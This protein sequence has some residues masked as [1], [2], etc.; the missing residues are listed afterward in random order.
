MGS[1]QQEELTILNIYGPNTGAPR[2]IRQV[3]NDLQKDLDSHTIIVG[4]FNTPLSILDRSTRQKINKDTQGLNSDLE[5]ANLVDIYRTL[6]PKST[7]YT[8]FSAPHHTYSKIDHI[9]GSKALLNKCKTTEIITNSLSDHSAIKLELRI[10]KP[11]QN[12]TASWKL[13][14]WLLN[15]DWVNNEMK[16]EIKKFFETN[17]NEDTTCQ[18]LWD[19]FKAVS[20]GKYIAI[21][22]H[23]RRM[24]R[25]KIDTLS[26][27]LKELEEQDQKNSK[28]SRRQEI[29]KIRAELKEIETRKTLQKINKSK[30]WFFEKINKID[31]PLAR[32]IKNKR[33]NNQI[34]AIKNDKGEITTDSTEIQTIIREYYKQLYAHKLV[35]LEEMD[36]FL[37]SCV[38]PSLNQEEAETMNR[39]I[40]RSEVEAAIK[41]LPHKKSPGP[42]GF[43]AEFYQT[44]K[45]ELEPFLLKLFQTIQK[46]GILPKSF[47]ETNIILI[48]KPGR[49]PTRKENF[50]PISMMNIDAKIFNKILASR[51]QQQ[52]KKLIHHDQVGFIPGM[53][54]WFNIRKSINVIHHINRTKNKNHMIIS[55]DA[56]KAFDK[57]QQPFMLKTLNKLGIDGTYIKVIKAIYDKPTANIILNGQ[58]LEAF[59]LKSGT[60]QGCPLSPLLFNIVLEVL[61]RAIRQEKEIKGIQIGKVEA[62]LSLFADD[63]IVYLEDPITS[64]QKLLKLINN[65][66][67]V[68]GYKINVQKSQAFVYTNNRL[69]ESQIKSELP[70]AIATK[71]I[72]Y[73]GIQLTRNVRDLFK[74]NYKPLLNEIREDTN[75][76]RNIPCSWLGRINIVKMAILPKVIYRINAIPIKLPL[77][78][79]TELEKTTMNF[80]WNQ[81][82]ARIA[83]SIL[84]KKNTA[85]GITLPDFKLYYKATVI[86]TA[87]YWYQNRD[88]D[89]W[90]KTEAP[91]ATQHT[92][93]YSIFDK[94]DKNKQ[95]GKDSMF[96]K[97]CWEN[98]LAMCRK[99]KLDP[100][101]TP[102]T[103]INSRWIKDLNIRPGT[104]KTL[105]GNLG[106]TIQD[107]GV[108]KDFMNKT[109]RALATKAKIDKWDL[110]KLH[111]FCTAK[112]TV[113]RVDRQPTEWEKIF[114]V[115]P[116]DKGLISRIY[117]QLKQIYRKKTNKPIQK[118]AK[119]M[120]RYF[121]KEDIYEANNHMKKCSS[122]LVI[123]E[124][125]IKT[126]LRYHLTPVRMA[127]IKKSGDNRCWRG[128]GE[129]G[130]LLHCWWE[131]KLVQPLWK[132]V[133]RFLKALEIEIPFDPAIPLLGIYPKDYKS[134]YY[135]DTCTRMFIAAL[136][137]IAKTWNQPKCP[138]IIDWIGKMWHIYT[139]EYYA[140]IRN[141]EFVSFVG[142]WMNL[143]NIILSKLTQEQK[144]KHRIFSLIGG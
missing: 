1:I 129:K 97:W 131:C 36:K 38:L 43:T 70:F 144:M 95:W 120:N 130:T 58:K 127:I 32:L 37:D 5:Q 59:P 140:A 142:T 83:K 54:G 6:H 10:Q 105:E 50:R 81:K 107:I 2:Y 44:H 7:E 112:E 64:A 104:I 17:E 135:K 90:N 73:L 116:S 100:F 118:W 41:S 15:V 26:S 52:I 22:A 8:F 138:L 80:I 51:L 53:Q 82:R 102:Y 86:K 33:E 119:D 92:Y 18:N 12:R 28:P 76:W 93:N 101:L 57:I 34:D 111:S 134:F 84:S 68:S 114:A 74:E 89:Q 113:T 49:D 109:P 42:D 61:A 88:I 79:F 122:S 110:M 126:T 143:E 35:N 124:M 121:T 4:D 30:S 87:W 62:K 31:R 25:S 125:Q 40:T 20:R 139:M 128:C 27:K 14:N 9:I 141:D 23:M 19:T 94:P 98:W 78:F 45:E 108:G 63:M 56:E 46:E 66:S 29:T 106:K 60:R 71:R 55:I 103:K 96:N 115:Y 67:K 16:A 132:T 11:T 136:F 48:P 99:Q 123:R 39:P 137:T 13:N 3:L 91:E 75:R 65:F 47:Y 21:S 85:G 69:K 133:W 24:E 117:K 72:K 77:T